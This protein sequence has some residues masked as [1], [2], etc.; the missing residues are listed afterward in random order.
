MKEDFLPGNRFARI[1]RFKE[2]TSTMD[3]CEE[4]IKSGVCRGMVVA[5]SQTSGRGRN[6]KKWVS[7][8]NGNIY[9][10]FFDELD[11]ELSLIP[12]RC[13][14]AA[15]LT[16]KQ[17]VGNSAEI[18][19]K[20]PNDILID[21]KKVSG[22]IA[23]TMLFEGKRFYIGGI[24]INVFPPEENGMKF[25][26][27][28][29]AVSEFAEVSTEDVLTALVKGTDFAFSAQCT[30]I[31]EIYSKNIEWMIGRGIVFSQ[32]L[33]HNETGTI[34]GFSDDFSIIKIMTDEGL[35]ELSALSVLSIK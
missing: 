5:E 7:V 21:M 12:Q 11:P 24:G 13:A 14:A 18:M 34:T 22:I 6:A 8:A 10:S 15:F 19:I 30:E 3:V 1:Y 4:L 29:A 33:L 9:L 32:D 27:E 35:K 16:V 26:W 28:P 31:I 25:V 20:W 2:V 23:K 17:F